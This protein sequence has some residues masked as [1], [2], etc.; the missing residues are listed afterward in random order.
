MN[1]VVAT[2][3]SR[4]SV[5]TGF[6]R[7]TVPN[8]ILEEIVRSGL[9][10]PSSK[11]AR[12][13]RLHVVTDAAILADLAS[14]VEASEDIES[15]VPFDPSTGQPRP[16]WKSTVLESA[17]I[18]RQVPAAVF[19]ENRGVFSGG[20]RTWLDAAPAAQTASIVGYTFE[21]IGVG[22]AIQNM[23]IAATAHGLSGVF[24]GDVLIAEAA[25]VQRLGM[26]G[27]LVGVLALG[28]AT[29]DDLPGRP[30]LSD[31]S[32]AN[33]RWWARPEGGR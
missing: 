25:I 20:K 29:G 24:M 22:A 10:A 15:Y 1:S 6:D 12:P 19:I 30:A 13:W 14:S 3:L 9:S 28:Y 4:R 31:A 26:V 32:D 5:R 11:N 18:L 33:V 16:E 8:E 27:D 21:I 23:W 17:D 2:I 7:T